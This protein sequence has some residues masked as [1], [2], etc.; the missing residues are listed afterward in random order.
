[1]ADAPGGDRTRLILTVQ[2]QTE[3][4]DRL[5]ASLKE[6]KEKYGQL[7]QVNAVLVEENQKLSG[8]QAENA[9]FRRELGHLQGM[10]LAFQKKQATIHERESVTLDAQTEGHR[11]EVRAYHEQI[12]NL[13]QEV[14]TLRATLQEKDTRVH[15]LVEQL[16]KS[17]S[18]A[19]MDVKLEIEKMRLNMVELQ[20]EVKHRVE[21]CKAVASQA[22]TYKIS[23]EAAQEDLANKDEVLLALEK[24]NH[25][26]KRNMSQLIQQRHAPRSESL[27]GV[28]LSSFSAAASP[29]QPPNASVSS[30]SGIYE[31]LLAETAADL[32]QP[33]PQLPTSPIQFTRGKS[34]MSRLEQYRQARRT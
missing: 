15:V 4:L 33:Q 1:M 27:P 3:T 8:L 28:R 22:E 2:R 14:T 21:Q 24:E 7:Q 25:A 29:L 9:D 10:V 18:P 12:K 19:D 34:A 17:G 16:T 23:L 32:N 31:P 5:H 30:A 20:K 11:A 13:T 26:Y 6:T